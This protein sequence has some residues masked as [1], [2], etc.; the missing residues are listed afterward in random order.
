MRDLA[1]AQMIGLDWGTTNL[2]AAL[3]DPDGNLLDERQDESGVGVLDQVGFE[4]RFETLTRDWPFV[5]A[6]A[7]GMVGSRQG[8]REAQYL[9]CPTGM[10]DLADALT[11]FEHQRRTVAIVPGLKM[12]T[13]THHDV[14]RGEETQIAGFLSFEPTFDG[15]LVLPG[16]HSK[17]V[18]LKG[19][20]VERFVT[21]MTGDM[22][23]AF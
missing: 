13:E 23:S 7:A 18:Q 3:L 1:K 2:R 12:A 22:F 16:T 20:I 19:G 5:P 21:Y 17:W 6:L 14:M 4:K 10:D 15:T 9:P 8:W 11:R